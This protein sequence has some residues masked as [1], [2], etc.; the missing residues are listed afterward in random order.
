M[1]NWGRHSEVQCF[2]EAYAT[3][4]CIIARSGAFGVRYTPTRIVAATSKIA[5]S[6]KRAVATAS[7]LPDVSGPMGCV[8]C[9]LLGSTSRG[10]ARALA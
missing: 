6:A 7:R 9:L 8:A 10:L 3:L 4:R 5:M 2:D 1:S